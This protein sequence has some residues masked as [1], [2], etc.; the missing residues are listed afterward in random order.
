MVQ[1]QINRLV[2]DR[3]TTVLATKGNTCITEILPDE[4]Y[5]E[6]LLAKLQY[7]VND[8]KGKHSVDSLVDALEVIYALGKLHGYTPEAMETM[9]QEKKEREG[10]YDHKK[11]LKAICQ[12]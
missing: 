12:F 8:Y 5:A 3:V 2:R 7:D 4:L 11:F 10:G 9:R 1:T 6:H